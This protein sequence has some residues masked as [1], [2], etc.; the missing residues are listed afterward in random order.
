MERATNSAVVGTPAIIGIS[1]V[2][3]LFTACFL[4]LTESMTFRGAV[5]HTYCRMFSYMYGT[6]H[7]DPEMSY[8]DYIRCWQ[9][10]CMYRENVA[11]VDALGHIHEVRVSQSIA[12]S[13]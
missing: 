7:V 1:R 2:Q 9:T 8:V 13:P 11:G 5:H 4:L 12:S 6:I 3:W 10:L